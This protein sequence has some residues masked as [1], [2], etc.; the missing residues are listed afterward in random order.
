[1]IDY[2]INIL[3]FTGISAGLLAWFVGLPKVLE[4]VSHFT[5][6]L[7]PIL[8]GLSQGIVEFIKILY[9][10][11]K[12]ILDNTKTILTVVFLSATIYLATIL[13][14][15][16]KC[17]LDCEQCIQNLRKDYKFIERTPE[18]K[19]LYLRKVNGT[20]GSYGESF[21]EIFDKFFR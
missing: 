14:N 2:L 8:K 1:M 13:Y 6:G 16:D 11:L 17:T 5:S 3:G 21:S 20:T 19:R 10:G 9:A 18:E 7:S 4:I 12:D 15:T